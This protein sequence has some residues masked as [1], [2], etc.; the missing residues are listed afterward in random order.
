LG[1]R[2]RKERESEEKKGGGEE[3]FKKEKRKKTISLLRGGPSRG[4]PILS[5]LRKRGEEEKSGMSLV[6]GVRRGPVRAERKKS[7]RK[8]KKKKKRK[9]RT[10]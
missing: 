1:E 3:N 2:K 9:K 7:K 4:V 6:A 5:V 10:A 8:T